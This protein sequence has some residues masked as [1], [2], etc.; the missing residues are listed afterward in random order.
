MSRGGARLGAGRKSNAVRAAI[1]AC[2]VAA[3]RSKGQMTPLDF[4]LAVMNDDEQDMRV[5]TAM[6]QAAAPYCH[7]RVAESAPG[8][9]E[10]ARTAAA[11]QNGLY[12]TRQ[13]PAGLV[14]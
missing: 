12:E 5:R 11:E 13:P 4:M 9:K 1:E 8:K 10:Q 7:G 3:K 14:N 2:E 6:A